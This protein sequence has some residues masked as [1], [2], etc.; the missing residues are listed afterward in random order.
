M[1]RLVPLL[2]ALCALL[3]APAGAAAAGCDLVAATNGNDRAAGTEAHPLRSPQVLADRL[4][5]GETG[6]LRG[7]TYADRDGEGMLI[8]FG[9]GGR[10]GRPLVLRSYPGERATLAGGVY[11]TRDA[12]D[13][14]ISRLTLDDPVPYPEHQ[15]MTVEL[16]AVR[17]TLDRLE[18]TNRGLKTCVIMGSAGYGQARGNVIRHSYFH[19]C[20]DPGNGLYDHAIYAADAVRTRIVGNR[21]LRTAGYAVHLYP[22][23]RHNLVKGNVMF[24]NGGGVI[25]AGEGD[26]ASSDNVVVGNVIRN[27]L[28]RP[29]ISSWW[30]G[31]VGHGNIARRNCTG[32]PIADHTGF[33]VTGNAVGSAC[34]AVVSQRVLAAVA[35]L[36]HR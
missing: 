16:N 2:I 15:E 6:C 31:K 12:P 25:F 34:T 24:D 26:E 29:D 1:R 36:S 30:G 11:V 3:T 8:R 18:I 20:G 22:Y 19:D 14:T 5:A 21:F 23:A 13:V 32:D 7:G 4:G 17:T 10:R 35:S 9:H 28:K 33:S 27:S